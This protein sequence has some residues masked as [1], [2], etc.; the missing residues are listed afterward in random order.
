MTS[1]RRGAC[2]RRGRVGQCSQRWPGS[3]ACAPTTARATAGAIQRP[4][5][6]PLRIQGGSLVGGL[7]ALDAG[8][9]SQYQGDNGNLQEVTVSMPATDGNGVSTLQASLAGLPSGLDIVLQATRPD[10]E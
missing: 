6:A 9:S 2:R 3:P 4:G 10:G 8:E 5:H 7:T 1:R